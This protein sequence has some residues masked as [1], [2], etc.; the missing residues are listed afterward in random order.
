MSKEIFKR[1]INKFIPIEADGVN[2]V[3]QS[4]I[5]FVNVKGKEKK[6]LSYIDV[7]S[8]YALLYLMKDKSAESVL[9]GLQWFFK[10]MGTPKTL[11]TDDDGAYKDVVDKYLK[12]VDVEHKIALGDGLVNKKIKT[13]MSIVERLHGSLRYSINVYVEENN[14]KTITQ[15]T[16]NELVDDYNTRKHR[17]IGVRPRDAIEGKKTPQRVMYKENIDIDDLKFEQ[18]DAVRLLIQYDAMEKGR[19]DKPKWSRDVY[20]IV[21]ERG[22][23]YKLSDGKWYP[24]TRL[25]KSKDPINVFYYKKED[26]TKYSSKKS[27]VEVIEENKKKKKKK[28]NLEKVKKMLS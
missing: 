2:D 27:E 20:Y 28:R 14:L 25:M 16:L 17:G 19:K 15:E 10:K 22:Y 21:N 12:F 18:G 24:Y 3:C 8:R 7:Y 6:I 11:Y 1:V 9:A 26:G 23:R 13:K 5:F 4:D